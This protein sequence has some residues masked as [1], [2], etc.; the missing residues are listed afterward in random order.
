[1]GAIGWAVLLVAGLAWEVV[2]WRMGDSSSWPTLTRLI[3]TYVPKG[4]IIAG[5]AW[6]GYHLLTQ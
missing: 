3:H 2:N 4:L 1:M 5:L 6:L